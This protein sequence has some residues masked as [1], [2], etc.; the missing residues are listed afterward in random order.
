VYA[1][2]LLAASYPIYRAA[3]R[4]LLFF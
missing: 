2:L 4:G 3:R 1:M